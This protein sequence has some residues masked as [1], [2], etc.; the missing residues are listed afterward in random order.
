M[1]TR[2]KGT[3]YCSFA[4]FILLCIFTYVSWQTNLQLMQ[5]VETFP[6]TPQVFL[7]GERLKWYLPEESLFV[8]AL[9]HTVIYRVKERGV[10]QQP[11][12]CGQGHR[13]MGE[14]GLRQICRPLITR[15]HTL[16]DSLPPRA[17]QP[18]SGSYIPSGNTGTGLLSGQRRHNTD[19]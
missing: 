12:L 15:P 10:P 1:S 13:D 14:P 16:S 6:Y 4:I 11:L 7:A 9:G 18:R 8:N 3:L 2:K 17:A 19:S 5:R